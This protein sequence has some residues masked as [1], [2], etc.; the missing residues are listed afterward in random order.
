MLL[1]TRNG[2]FCPLFSMIFGYTRPIPMAILESLNPQQQE[3]VLH[4]TGPLLI[5]AG[6]G[7]GKTKTIAH[8]IAYRISQGTPPEKILAVTFTNK[9]AGEMRERIFALLIKENLNVRDGREPFIG[10]FHAL[11]ASL[12][13]ETGHHIGIPRTFSII[14]EEDSR[15]VVKNL[16]QEYELDPEAYPPHR[17]RAHISSLKNELVTPDALHEQTDDSPYQQHLRAIYAAYEA[18]LYKT[19]SLDFDDLLLKTVLLLDHHEDTRAQ[20]EK[21]WDYIHIDEYQDTNKAQYLLSRIL[22]RAHGNIAVVGDV[23]QAIYSWRGANWRNILQ[24]EHDWPGTKVILLEENYRSTKIILEAANAVIQYNTERKEK[25]LWSRTEGEDKV[26]ISLLEDERREG[27]FITEY[28]Q[29]L[30]HDGIPAREIAVLFRTNAQSRAIEEAFLKNHIPYRLFAGV[31]FYERKEIKDVLAYLKYALNPDD[32]LSKKRIIN[33]PARG[34]G[35]VLMLKYIGGAPLSQKDSEKIKKFEDIIKNIKEY[36]H[37]YKTS[38][39]L[40][41]TLRVAGFTTYYKSNTLEIDR[42][43]NVDELLS[44]AQKFDLLPPPEG[45]ERLLTEASLA[46]RDIEIDTGDSEVTLLTAH[47]AKGLEFRVVIIAGMEEGLFPHVL[48]ETASDIEEERRLFY[49]ALTRAKE[50]IH[51][52]LTR[53][54]MIYGNIS[55]NDP[56]R[57]LRELPAHLVEGSLLK[58]YI[59]EEDNE[60]SIW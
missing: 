6:A 56:S 3:A 37:T 39:A 42:K 38:R 34:I 53:K 21:R 35:K 12:L 20:Y 8:R 51:I 45:I 47:A 28:I 31:K 10:T 4:E 40:S 50:K 26:R 25:N 2:L 59:Y 32:A 49:V 22:A 43:E 18:T 30:K 36:I 13:R 11:G 7:S 48:S 23:D 57:F 27:L 60:T 41:S 54:R 14:D 9:A 46:S 19:K 58:D 15:S 55:F 29:K 52:T 33:T 24:F 5:I 44:V 16:I 17:I 1:W